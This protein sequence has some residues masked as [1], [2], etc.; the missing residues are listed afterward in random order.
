VTP[1]LQIVLSERLR[2]VG[3]RRGAVTDL[4]FT[5]DLYDPGEVPGLSGFT[6]HAQGLFLVYSSLFPRA[7]PLKGVYLRAGVEGSAA[8][9]G[10]AA[11]YWR[12]EGQ[13]RAYVPARGTRFVTVVKISWNEV[14]G[15]G[16]PFLERSVLG[17]E[18]TLRGYGRN[19]FVDMAFALLNIEER[20][21]LF[22]W[23][24]FNVTADWEA[25]PF[26]DVGQVAGSLGE[27]RLRDLKVNPGIALRAAVRPNIA[28]RIEIG[29]GDEGV[30]V[31]VGLG[32][33]F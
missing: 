18:N 30:A 14:R 23:R 20:I 1:R 6:A 3:V 11:D 31:F 13:G 5:G 16:V 4:P 8:A 22:R 27:V 29:Y 28:G 9:L 26:V 10:G 24:V 7:L 15:N 32:Y 21:T 2:N 25:S 12:W 33:P 17:G 19:R